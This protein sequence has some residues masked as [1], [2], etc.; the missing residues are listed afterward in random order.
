MNSYLHPLSWR[1]AAA[2]I[3]V[4]GATC[5]GS[6]WAQVSDLN[7]RSGHSLG[8]DLSAYTYDEPALMSLKAKQLGVDYAFTYALGG[9]WPRSNEGWFVRGEWRIASGKADYRSP[10]SGDI[11]GTSNGY[12]EARGLVGRDF[13]RGSYVLA[14]FVGLGLRQLRN[15]LRGSTSTGAR[16]YRRASEY[17]SLPMGLTHRMKLADQSQLDTTVEYMHLISGLQTARLSDLSASNP[18]LSLKQRRG[19]GL[20]LKVM[21]RH[22]NWSWGPS[23][24]YWNIS[25]SDPSGTPAYIEPK[26]K[27]Y[28]L[29]LKAAYHF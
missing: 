24:T 9:T 29:G 1:L 21:N 18:D 3:S 8:L 7:T 15:D 11:D 6:S 5:L 23:L 12:M 16:G 13:D 22:D 17:T 28:E 10:I 27:T 25:A 26:N 14:P 19:H 20:R 4:L 2:A